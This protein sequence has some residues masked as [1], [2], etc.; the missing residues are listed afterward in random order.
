MLDWVL[1]S[2]K[3]TR[4]GFPGSARRRPRSLAW[5]PRSLDEGF[6]VSQ[7]HER[8]CGIETN[9]DRG[10]SLFLAYCC[11]FEGFGYPKA[12]G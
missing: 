3:W 10:L 1:D 2:W 12:R 6:W 8:D 5:R 11:V 4:W 7:K 9:G